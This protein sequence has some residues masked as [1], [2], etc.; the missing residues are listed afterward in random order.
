MENLFWN[1]QYLCSILS[2]RQPENCCQNCCQMKLYQLLGH[3]VPEYLAILCP[4]TRRNARPHVFCCR[5]SKYDILWT[6]S[7]STIILSYVQRHRKLTVFILVHFVCA[8]LNYRHV[9]SF[10]IICTEL[11]NTFEDRRKMIN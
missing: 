4:Q 9:D 1:D 2:N 10:F 6:Y 11:F 3:T 7:Q 5:Y 8:S